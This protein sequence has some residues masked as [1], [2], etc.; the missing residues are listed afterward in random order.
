MRVR[1]LNGPVRHIARAQLMWCDVGVI[2]QDEDGRWVPDD[3]DYPS[4][5]DMFA[6]PTALTDVELAKLRA[7][8]QKLRDDLA[9]RCSSERERRRASVEALIGRIEETIQIAES[10]SR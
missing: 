7:I 8:P 3:D 9:L 2:H 5:G 6:R 10:A 4:L 1:L